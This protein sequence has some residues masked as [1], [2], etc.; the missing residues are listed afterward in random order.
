VAILDFILA[1]ADKEGVVQAVPRKKKKKPKTK[2]PD[3]P[4]VKPK[5]APRLPG[6]EGPR[7]AGGGRRAS[8]RVDTGR[9]KPAPVNLQRVPLRKPYRGLANRSHMEW[10]VSTTKGLV[11]LPCPFLGNLSLMEWEVVMVTRLILL[12]LFSENLNLM[13]WTGNCLL[14]ESRNRTAWMAA[15]K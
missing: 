5:A 4:T 12:F 7:G 8:M 2:K 3:L 15:Q 10:V 6:M 14:N 9:S 1:Q 13:E 11:I